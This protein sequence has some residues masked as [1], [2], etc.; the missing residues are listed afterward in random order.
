MNIREITARDNAAIA[1]IIR[2]T[3]EE[4]H[5]D[6]PGTAY[7]DPELDRFSEYYAPKGR[8]YF[9]CET[10]DGEIVGGCGYAEFEGDK[11]AE[12]QKLY[13]IPAFRGKG[14]SSKL[15]ETVE[16]HAK[17]DGYYTLYLETH[18]NLENAVRIYRDK[19]YKSLEKPL[20]NSP[21]TTMDIFFVKKIA[22]NH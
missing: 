6:L 17:A 5:L 22:E 7:Y 9:V 21:H 12:M 1:K 13:L 8:R 19:G 3:L 20:G 14:L 10:G 4:F 16:R 18:H 15:I 2:E 11:T